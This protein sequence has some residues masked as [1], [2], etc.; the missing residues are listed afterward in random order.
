MNEKAK[1]LWV[2]ALLSG[3]YEQTSGALMRDTGSIGEEKHGFCCLG[4]LCDVYHNET[5]EGEWSLVDADGS[6]WYFKDGE[7]SAHAMLLPKG[8]ADWAD[9]SLS[10]HVK[11]DDPDESDH[12]LTELNDR[13]FSFKHI[14]ALIEKNF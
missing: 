6:H 7:G 12:Y 3:D 2:E 9:L 4:V 5:G 11:T 10:P 13:G 8:V 14:A 1:R